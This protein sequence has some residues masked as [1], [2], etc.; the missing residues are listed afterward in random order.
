[1]PKYLYE[2]ENPAC[3]S[4]GSFYEH[5]SMR[6][7]PLRLCPCCGGKAERII[8]PVGLAAPTGDSE[9]RD[10]GFAKLVRRD[11]GVYENVT[12][13]DHESRYYHADRPETM[14]D[15]RRRVGD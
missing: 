10:K 6:D 14:P 7:E 12:A 9:L 1:M 8:C 5:Q 3:P 13:M 2:C 4:G 15:I 11:K